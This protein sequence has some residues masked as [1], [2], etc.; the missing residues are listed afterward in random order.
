M[1]QSAAHLRL[2]ESNPDVVRVAPALD[3][4]DAEKK[5]FFTSAA[6]CI[7]TNGVAIL[8][9]VIPSAVIDEV[10][11]HFK[12]T[13]DLH[14]RPGQKK[15]FRNDQD[16]PLRAQIPVAPTGAMAN[17]MMFAN[18]WVMPLVHEFIGKKVIIGEMGAVISHPGSQ[19]QY[20]HRDSHFLFGGIPAE[21]DLPPHSLNIVVPLMDVPFEMGPTEYWPGSHKRTDSD[22]VTATPPKRVAFKKGTAFMLDARLLH[23]GGPNN[24]NVVR[25]TVYIDY[26]RP[27][28][29]E[30]SGYKDKPQVR[31]T[32]TMVDALAPEHRSLFDWA[33]HLN[34][35]DSVDEFLTRWA[36]R[37][38]TR[39]M[40]PLARRFGARK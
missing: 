21:F 35:T 20:I 9:N 29:L 7:R 16:D 5:A 4:S 12:A 22:A 27:W 8:E 32:Q 2:A 18:P 13:Y 36:G 40:D 11:A 28:Y 3:A 37:V 19:P 24:S 23:R 26:Q 1:A 31:V 30:R 25:P 39:L 6:D 38:K 14:M 17:P 15:L 10:L 34:R 33:L